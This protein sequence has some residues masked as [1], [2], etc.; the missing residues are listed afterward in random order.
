MRMHLRDQEVSSILVKR[1]RVRSPFR[2][3][4]TK[5]GSW[6]REKSGLFSDSC[7][8]SVVPLPTRPAS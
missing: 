6:L 1:K 3:E 4:G 5:Y 8:R 7:P 2:N